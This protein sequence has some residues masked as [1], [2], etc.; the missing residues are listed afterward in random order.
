MFGGSADL[1][2]T[3]TNNYAAPDGDSDFFIPVALDPSPVPSAA[4]RSNTE[5]LD[6]R[7][8]ANNGK[9]YFARQSTMPDMKGETRSSAASTPHIAFQEKVRRTSSEYDASSQKESPP[10]PSSSSKSDNSDLSQPQDSPAQDKPSRSNGKPD[11][12]KLQD[13]PKSKKLSNNRAPAHTDG[14]D[15][16]DSPSTADSSPTKSGSPP[17]SVDSS[18]LPA[19]RSE[20]RT[21]LED[22]RQVSETRGTSRPGDAEIS[23][24]IPRKEVPASA[25]SRNG[26]LPMAASVAF[27]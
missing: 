17:R 10:K 16:L 19:E 22:R 4:S 27:C 26:M 12:F 23:K 8:K 15:D 24:A 2:G 11:E 1:S 25:V 20:R 21:R 18:G 9:D 6:Q 3:A 7:N 13:A 14:L 5:P